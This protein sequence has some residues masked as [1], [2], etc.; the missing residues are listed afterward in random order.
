MPDT[1]RPGETGWARLLGELE[2]RLSAWQAALDGDGA[3]PDEFPWPQG[4]GRC[5]VRLEGR[6]RRILATQ[7]DLQV[8]LTAR[9]AAVGT[10]LR[11][12]DVP[13]RSMATALFVDQ[14]C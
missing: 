8:R 7:R 6:A 12:A 10:F 11:R 1:S 13:R 5:P 2:S 4:L 14:R 3:F 9:H